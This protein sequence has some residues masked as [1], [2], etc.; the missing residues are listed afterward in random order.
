MI[1]FSVK[2]LIIYTH[3]IRFDSCLQVCP[4]LFLFNYSGIFYMYFP[5]FIKTQFPFEI[6]KDSHSCIKTLDF[7][8]CS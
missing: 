2:D 7:G 5:D 4:E 6:Q 1:D 8:V 3:S